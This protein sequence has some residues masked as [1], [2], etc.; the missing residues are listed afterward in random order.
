MINRSMIDGIFPHNAKKAE[1]SPIYKKNSN[2]DKSNYRPVSVLTTLSKIFEKVV[3]GQLSDYFQSHYSPDMSGFRTHHGCQDVLL[4]FVEQVKSSTDD[5]NVTCTVL[6]DLSR[7]FDCLP[8]RLLIAKLYFYG[9]SK[10]AC[11]LVMNYFT[12]RQQRVKLNREKSDWLNIFKGTPQGS[13]FGPFAYNVFTND[14][15]LRMSEFCHIYNYADDNTISCTGEKIE[16][17]K[18]NMSIA[19]DVMLD[20]FEMNGLKAN[21]DKFQMIMFGRNMTFDDEYVIV[22]NTSLKHQSCVKLLGVHID[23][24]LNFSNHVKELCKKAGYKL[25][26]LGRLSGT[27]NQESKVLLLHSFIL[28]YFNYCPVVWHFCDMR[29]TKNMEKIQERALRFIYKDFTSSYDVLRNMSLKPLLYVQRLRNL[30]IEVYKCFNGIG[31]RYMHHIF[32]PKNTKYN[33]RN[34]HCLEIPRHDTCKYGFNTFKYQGAKLWNSLEDDAKLLN[35]NMFK[36]FMSKWQPQQCQCSVC[37]L[38][39]L[40]VM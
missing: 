31:P 38:C 8:H 22:N 27:L 24:K 5:K 2:L 39:K 26:V 37:V 33:L 29:S 21:P 17:V 9:V 20:W 28:S 6:T 35:F 40:Q 30:N 16:D 13:V 18:A 10:S 14:L 12:N 4:K 32:Q 15:L 11:M 23:A 34:V 3:V 36:Q 25:N 19:L 7:A 1:V